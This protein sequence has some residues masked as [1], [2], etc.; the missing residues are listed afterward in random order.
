[1][2]D[3]ISNLI[4]WILNSHLP[5]PSL[6]VLDLQTSYYVALLQ[7]IKVETK[8][9]GYIQIRCAFV[10]SPQEEKATYLRGGIRRWNQSGILT[11]DDMINGPSEMGTRRALREYLLVNHSAVLMN[12]ADVCEFF[13]IFIWF[14]LIFLLFNSFSQP[15]TPE[16]KKRW[17]FLSSFNDHLTRNHRDKEWFPERTTE[18]IAAQ[19][20][21]QRK[22]QF[23]LKSISALAQL[24][25]I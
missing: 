5:R 8:D 17:S 18:C 21:G 24:Q 11:I 23:L 10:Q 25:V 14:V 20:Q 19:A 2:K 13:C 6:S 4:L 9:Y 12:P 7:K 3:L 1:M 15:L 16:A 22:P